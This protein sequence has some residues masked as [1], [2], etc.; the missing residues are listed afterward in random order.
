MI[1]IKQINILYE[2]LRIGL[3]GG[4]KELEVKN[5]KLHE[6]LGDNIYEQELKILR[7]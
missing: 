2:W 5:L 4:S 3:K 7:S 6:E 1:N